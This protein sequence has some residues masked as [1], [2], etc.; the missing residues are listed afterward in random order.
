MRGVVGRGSAGV[1]L[2]GHLPPR[3]RPPLP[4]SRCALSVVDAQGR[5][6]GYLGIPERPGAGIELTLTDEKDMTRVSLAQEGGSTSI[7]LIDGTGRPSLVLTANWDGRARWGLV[8]LSTVEL[9]GEDAG[10]RTYRRGPLDD[11]KTMHRWP[12]K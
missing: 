12:E 11:N 9:G 5:T 8:K 7:R 4:T 2:S 6:R 3:R 1:A 10:A